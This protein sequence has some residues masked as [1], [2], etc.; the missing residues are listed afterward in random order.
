MRD[1]AGVRME[2][3]ETRVP[4]RPHGPHPYLIPGVYKGQADSWGEA[5]GSAGPR[6]GVGT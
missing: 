2:G 3:G 5:G 1:K 6:A 4:A